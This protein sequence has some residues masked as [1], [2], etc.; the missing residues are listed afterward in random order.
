MKTKQLEL[1]LKKKVPADWRLTPE[2]KLQRNLSGFEAYCSGNNYNQGI[3]HRLR[4]KCRQP[5]QTL[6]SILPTVDRKRLQLKTK[7]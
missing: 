7:Q 5:Q 1:Q 3:L 4:T 2:S 6:R